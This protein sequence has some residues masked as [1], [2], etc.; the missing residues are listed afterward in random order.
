MSDVEIVYSTHAPTVAGILWQVLVQSATT[1]VVALHAL[2]CQQRS[3]QRL[4]LHSE[5]ADSPYADDVVHVIG[6]RLTPL[7]K[8]LS[9]RLE[10]A[11]WWTTVT[12]SI[13]S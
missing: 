13:C 9:S 1:C 3:W 2:L 10:L 11:Y 4:A 5:T 12:Y 7:K 6:G 8:L